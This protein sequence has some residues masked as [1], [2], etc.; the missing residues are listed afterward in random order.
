M[1]S[2]WPTR[3]FFFNKEVALVNPEQQLHPQHQPDTVSTA[4]RQTFEDPEG[5]LA[6]DLP[7][8][9]AREQQQCGRPARLWRSAAANET[10]NHE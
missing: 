2:G 6:L 1:P 7:V 10:S 4:S 3:P 8:V 5:G 9:Q